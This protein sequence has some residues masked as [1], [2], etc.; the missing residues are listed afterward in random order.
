[1]K[2]YD[3]KDDWIL[4]SALIKDR[5]NQGRESIVKIRGALVPMAKVKKQ[6]SRHE[7]LLAPYRAPTFSKSCLA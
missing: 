4:I 7:Y 3:T 6:I 2:K 5:K 1:M